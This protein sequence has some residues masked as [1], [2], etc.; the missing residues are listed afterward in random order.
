MNKDKNKYEE[1]KYKP[2]KEGKQT[3]YIKGV[4]RDKLMKV[5]IRE[6]GKIFIA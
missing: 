2:P 6:L 5:E 4:R 1:T 3:R